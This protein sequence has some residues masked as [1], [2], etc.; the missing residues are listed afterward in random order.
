MVLEFEPSF[1]P[2]DVNK[3][4]DYGGQWAMAMFIESSNSEIR[5]QQRCY[6]DADSAAPDQWSWSSAMQL[7]SYVNHRP[8]LSASPCSM[9]VPAC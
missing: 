7:S 8:L 2:S 9:P 6:R 1:V 4:E 3:Q 5:L